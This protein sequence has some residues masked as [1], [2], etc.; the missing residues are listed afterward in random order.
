MDFFL[1]WV[2]IFSKLILLL[3]I[4]HT[5]CNY[6]TILL[7]ETKDKYYWSRIK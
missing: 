1:E 6:Y 3:E 5:R 4:K 7:T 2:N